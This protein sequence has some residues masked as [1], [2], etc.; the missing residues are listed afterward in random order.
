LPFL[1]AT[2]NVDQI[3]V[4]DLL[5]NGTACLVWSSDLPRDAYRPMRYLDLMGGKKPHLL[6]RMVNNLGAETEVEY[7]P[8]TKYYLQDKA[9]GTPWATR[10]PFPVQCVETVTIRD[11]RCKT[12]FST[13]YSY[14]HG[15]FDGPAEREFRGFGRVEQ[16]DTERFDDVADAN[17]DSPYVTPDRDLFQPPVKTITWFHT[18]V[19]VDRHRILGAFEHEYF[20]S[21]F[22][23]RLGT[24]VERDLPQPEIDGGGSP[25]SLSLRAK[26]SHTTTT[27]PLEGP[28][29]LTRT[30]A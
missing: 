21:R 11:R 27:C 10:L 17:A 20:P 28:L 18:G 24:S 23:S 6:T 19:A 9:A 8:S 3:Q 25:S 26:P 2:S 5:G 15:C 30:R 7:A 29:R 22:A 1:K 4:A 14:H 16:V 12:E 13:T